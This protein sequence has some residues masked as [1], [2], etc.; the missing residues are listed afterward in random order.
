MCFGVRDAVKRA[1]E[2][3][4]RG[5]AT[6]LGELVH[7]PVVRERLRRLGLREAGL[8]RVGEVA[9]GDVVITAHGASDR[10]RA[11]WREAGYRVTDTTCPLVRRAHTA[12]AELAALGCRL[13]VIGQAGHVEVRG[14]TGDFPGATV[15]LTE[16]EA[17]AVPYAPRI[18]VVAQ[19][20]QP[21]ERVRH[22]VDVLRRRHPAAEVLFRD[23]VCQPTKDRQAALEK[24]CHGNPVVIV[25]GG[26]HSNN[27]RQ[28]VRKA[29]QLGAAA[30]H[31]EGPDDL[32]PEWF[33]GVDRVGITAGTST[34]DET[35]QAVARRIR[36]MAGG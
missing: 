32:Q 20:T 16:E 28:L 34:P 30:R 12:M 31:V 8:D 25:V 21:V 15:I 6:V 4:A 27:T 13:V 18:G 23:T 33:A 14:L 3:A 11:A 35:V 17:E 22:L 29:E 26:R 36:E 2:V 7:N 1:E 19:T 24:L 9:T 10:D 5:P